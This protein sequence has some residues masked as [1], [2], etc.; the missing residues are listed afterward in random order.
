[1][2]R[3][4]LAAV[5]A[6]ATSSV[7]IQGAAIAQFEGQGSVGLLRPEAIRILE[8]LRKPDRDLGDLGKLNILD[9]NGA[10]KL[11]DVPK[12]YFHSLGFS[13]GSSAVGLAGYKKFPI[14]NPDI[15]R[16]VP[17]GNFAGS[18][19]KLHPGADIS[20]LFDIKLTQ[21]CQIAALKMAEMIGRFGSPEHNGIPNSQYA[22]AVR[23]Y[24]LHCLS[25]EKDIPPELSQAG[26]GRVTGI[27]T[28]ISAD[29]N[30]QPFCGAFRFASKYIVTA[31]HCLFDKKS[32]LPRD[33]VDIRNVRLQLLS[34]P[35]R[36]FSVA[37]DKSI[38]PPPSNI[39]G[40]FADHD[41]YFVLS[42]SLLDLPMPD[43]LKIVE[44][45]PLDKLVLVGFHRH[46]AL[47]ARSYQVAGL[48]GVAKKRTQTNWKA[49]LRGSKNGACIVSVSDPLCIV[50]GCQTE[51][52]YSGLPIF[53]RSNEG[54]LEVA[55]LHTR[56]HNSAKEC[57]GVKAPNGEIAPKYL[58]N[59][60]IQLNR[61]EIFKN[62][63][64]LE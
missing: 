46:I 43:N 23:N 52:G 15:M 19:S 7:T 59:V 3:A 24:D 37:I 38:P 42:V 60:G 33:G 22:K 36:S 62:L 6:F 63:G 29:G 48:T 1:M 61:I 45:R 41:D 44:S 34:F 51:A 53:R 31:R 64:L 17:G 27:L 2:I 26:L 9:P 49:Y 16:V 28:L 32:G 57:L 5:V 58:G 12:R 21:K 50:H 18:I 56:G 13:T 40:G 54:R 30:V 14:G 47:V 11:L 39:F 25:R 55:G 20:S 4:L 35:K 10:G 8:G